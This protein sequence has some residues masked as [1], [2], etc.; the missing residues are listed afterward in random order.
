MAGA[1]TDDRITEAACGL[2]TPVRVLRVAV[3]GCIVAA[4][5]GSAPLRGWTETLPD[6]RF[7]AV[8]RDAA[9]QWNDAMTRIGAPEPRAWLRAAIRSLEARRFAE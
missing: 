5:F 3:I 6:G 4:A 2:G 1:G 9:M 8:A 7:T